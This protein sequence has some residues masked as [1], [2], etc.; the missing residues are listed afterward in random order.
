MGPFPAKP[1]KFTCGI[2]RWLYRPPIHRLRV[3]RGSVG[4]YGAWQF[5]S[6]SLMSLSWL[7][8]LG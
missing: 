8:S 3:D 6:S 5:G 4:R 2:L 7:C 1:W